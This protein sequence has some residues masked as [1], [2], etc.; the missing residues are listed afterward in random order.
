MIMSTAAAA[1][2]LSE[3]CASVVVTHHV[4]GLHLESRGETRSVPF[5]LFI[6]ARYGVEMG[7]LNAGVQCYQSEKQ[8]AEVE[9]DAI[10]HCTF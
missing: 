6:N 9:P 10:S 2:F 4:I 1:N 5:R 8:I 3:E 7:R